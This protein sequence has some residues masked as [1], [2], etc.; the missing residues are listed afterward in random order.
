MTQGNSTTVG[1]DL[2][3]V[4]AQL[5]H[6]VDALASKGFIQ[7]KDANVALLDTAVFVEVTDGENG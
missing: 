6:T 2:G 4:N 5:A 3:Y 7:F 1:V